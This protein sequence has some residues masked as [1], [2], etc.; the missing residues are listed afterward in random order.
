MEYTFH[1]LVIESTDELVAG[2][3]IQIDPKQ[4]LEMLGHLGVQAT[5]A[6]DDAR[7]HLVWARFPVIPLEVED[8]EV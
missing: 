6:Y 5:E 1:E 8:G 4:F 7:Q 2:E 3:V